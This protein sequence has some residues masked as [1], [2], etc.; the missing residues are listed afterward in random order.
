MVLF[1][2]LLQVLLKQEHLK[3]RSDLHTFFISTVKLG[4]RD[5]QFLFVIAVIRN[6]REPLC[7]KMNIWD[8]KILQI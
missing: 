7:T 4:L 6:N 2:R 5:L 1:S 8:P 3:L